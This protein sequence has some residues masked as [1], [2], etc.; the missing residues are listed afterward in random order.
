MV[1]PFT[2]KAAPP[3]APA[4]QPTEAKASSVGALI[5]ARVLKMPQWPQRSFEQIAKEAYQ[6]NPVVNACVYL[7]ARAAASIPLDIMRGDAEI[8]I[9][10]LRALLDRPN[11]AQDG[12]AYRQATISDLMLA[13]EFFAERVDL[14]AKPKELY[15][16]QPGCVTVD[17]GDK[18]FPESYTFKTAGRARTVPV[19]FVTGKVPILHVKDYNP[20]ND[21]RGLPNVDPAAFAIDMH[22]GGLRWN[23]ALLEN[24][25]QPSGAMEYAPKEGSEKL[26]DEQFARLKAELDDQYSGAK[27]AGRPLL[28]DGGMKWTPMGY[29]PKDMNFEDGMNVAARQIALAFGVPPLILSIPG[30]NTFANYTEA[31]KAFYRQ[32]VLPLLRQWCRAHSWWLAGAFGKDI[33]IVPDEDD[34]DVFA[35]ERAAYRKSVEEST[36]LQVDEKREMAW[37]VK[38]TPGGDVVLVPSTMIPLDMAGEAQAG[39]AAPDGEDDAPDIGGDGEDEGA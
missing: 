39:G 31:N 25:A 13:G 1:W 27:N 28:L 22:T 34:L 6:Q 17:P 5:A 8:D 38:P 11:P 7:T 3:P 2:R 9:P 18:G 16:W 12:E 23:K 24:S 29:S 33:R 35:D 4:Q 21:W 37:G 36:V 30:D 10:E 32:T 14:G 20:I 26:T 15:R 19:D